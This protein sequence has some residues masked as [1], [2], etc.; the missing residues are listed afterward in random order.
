MPV[1]CSI[2]ASAVLCPLKMVLRGESRGKEFRLYFRNNI[3][4]ASGVA[5]KRGTKLFGFLF[6]EKANTFLLLS[7]R[8]LS[9]FPI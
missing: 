3:N 4:K 2:S 8:E 6:L 1:P 9:S 5:S 7:Q